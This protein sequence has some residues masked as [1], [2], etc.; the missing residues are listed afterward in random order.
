MTDDLLVY[1]SSR[2]ERRARIAGVLSVTAIVMLLVTSFTLARGVQ[3][4]TGAGQSQ[5][6]TGDGNDAISQARY[7]TAPAPTI[8]AMPCKLRSE[9]QWL[10]LSICQQ[11]DLTLAG[12]DCIYGHAST[13]KFAQ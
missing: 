13:E 6:N 3:W 4:T 7:K 12:C 9:G 2:D 11:G 1:T 5:V 10:R 8:N